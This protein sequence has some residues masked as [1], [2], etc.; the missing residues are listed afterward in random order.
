MCT[1]ESFL[2]SLRHPQS[3]QTQY[4]PRSLEARQCLPFTF[5]DGQNRRMKWVGRGESF[6]PAINWKPF[7]NLLP[8]FENPVRILCNCLACFVRHAMPLKK[9]PPNN[10][11]SLGFSRHHHGF[12]HPIKKLLESLF[13][14]FI[15]G[16]VLKF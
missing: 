12:A 15:F 3:Q 10:F 11:R 9:P 7:G 6:A 13:V 14:R 16:C 5:E 4:A 8:V 1:L 2:I